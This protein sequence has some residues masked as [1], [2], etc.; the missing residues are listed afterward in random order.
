MQW[1]VGLAGLGHV[2]QAAVFFRPQR[3]VDKPLG[4]KDGF[5]GAV[6]GFGEQRQKIGKAEGCEGRLLGEGNIGIAGIGWRAVR[7]QPGTRI[8]EGLTDLVGANVGG[9]IAAAA[10]VADL[11]IVLNFFG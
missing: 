9:Q 11:G 1:V 2:N 7:I 8:V 4:V 6:G 3:A 5:H 10:D